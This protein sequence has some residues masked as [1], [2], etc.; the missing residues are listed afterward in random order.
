MRRR[1]KILLGILIFASAALAFTYAGDN[2]FEVAKNLD[3]FTTLF[4]ELNTYY[5]DEIDPA[6][7]VQSGI[8]NML[9]TLDPYTDYIPEEDAENFSIQTTGQYAGIGAL[10]TTIDK[11]VYISQPYIGFPAQQAGISWR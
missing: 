1:I 11:R 9:Q 5:V 7:L 2:Y 4:K 8:S 10:I 6:K 3:I